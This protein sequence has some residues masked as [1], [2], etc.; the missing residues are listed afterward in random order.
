MDFSV[1]LK[2]LSSAPNTSLGCQF[3]LQGL[4]LVQAEYLRGS[5][6]F[7]PPPKTASAYWDSYQA[8]FRES[9]PIS[10]FDPP[11]DSRPNGSP[12]GA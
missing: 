6:R 3:A 10:T 5:G 7:L 11:A 2:F 9:S 4:H 1:L 8:L 12:T